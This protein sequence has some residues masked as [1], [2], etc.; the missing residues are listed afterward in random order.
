MVHTAISDCSVQYSPIYQVYSLGFLKVGG[1]RI[2]FVIK[3]YKY[4]ELQQDG[5]FLFLFLVLS[6]NVFCVEKCNKT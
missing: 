1:L 4:G 5:W 3:G 2:Y 6:Q